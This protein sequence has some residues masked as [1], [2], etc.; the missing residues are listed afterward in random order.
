MIFLF[1]YISVYLYSVMMVN[2]LSVC[3]ERDKRREKE[4]EGGG[5][6][7]TQVD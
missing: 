6:K 2:L 3:T 7:L 4:R 5:K 1:I